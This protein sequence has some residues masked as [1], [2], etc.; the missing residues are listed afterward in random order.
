MDVVVRESISLELD[1]IERL[2][3]KILF[4]IASN[5]DPI[6]LWIINKIGEINAVAFANVVNAYDPELITI[7]GSIAIN[8]PDLILKPIIEN[9]EKHLINR[10]PEIILTPLRE[11]VVLYGAL[12]LVMEKVKTNV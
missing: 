8:N 2:T 1:Y 12:A 11:D 6:G 4:Q 3:T 10:K 5:S 7:G 9:I